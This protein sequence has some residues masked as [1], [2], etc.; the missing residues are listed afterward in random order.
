M[1]GLKPLDSFKELINQLPNELI[2]VL[3][4]LG[5]RTNNKLIIREIIIGLCSIQPLSITELSHLLKRDEKYLKKNYLRELIEN[6]ELGYTIP[7]MISH[8]DQ[9]YK[10]IKNNE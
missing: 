6:K 10:A 2:D 9:K 4:N 7:Q 5:K 3:T 8:P 1:E